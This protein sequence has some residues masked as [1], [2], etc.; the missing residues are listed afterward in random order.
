M[1]HTNQEQF[2][3]IQS[4]LFLIQFSTERISTKI[5]YVP[6]QHVEQWLSPFWSKT[7]SEFVSAVCFFFTR[8]SISETP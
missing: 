7:E 3:S 5:E 8:T 4:D 6:S 2:D 1:W